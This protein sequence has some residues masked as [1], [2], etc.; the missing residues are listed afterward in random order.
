MLSKVK[1]LLRQNE[2]L[3][4]SLTEFIKDHTNSHKDRWEH[5]LALDSMHGME[6]E[7]SIYHGFDS[8]V[9]DDVFMYEG[10]VHCERYQTVSLLESIHN[11]MDNKTDK[12][13]SDLFKLRLAESGIAVPTYGV[14][15]DTLEQEAVRSVYHALEVV[16]HKE[17]YDRPE[18][19]ELEQKLQAQLML[20]LVTTFYYDW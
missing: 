5:F 10:L 9:G 11:I 3:C 20:D 2:V 16:C 4:S 14:E 18:F 6:E 12:V 7:S 17:V 15:Y 13:L 1:D 19:Q 8:I